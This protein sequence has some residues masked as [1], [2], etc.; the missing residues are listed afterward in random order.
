MNSME[1]ENSGKEKNRD[2]EKESR[3]GG[4]R[5]G[6]QGSDVVELESVGVTTGSRSGSGMTASSL[7]GGGGGVQ[8]DACVFRL[9]ESMALVHAREIL[10]LSNRYISSQLFSCLVFSVLL[11]CVVLCCV[12]L[13]CV[14]CV[15]FSCYCPILSCVVCCLYCTCVCFISSLYILY[16]YSFI[17][18]NHLILFYRLF[19]S[20][21]FFPFLLFI[22]PLHSA[23]FIIFIFLHFTL[24]SFHNHSLFYFILLIIIRT[25]S[26][27]DTYFCIDTLLRDTEQDF[28][29]L[30]PLGK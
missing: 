26:G 13:C 11:C 5:G 28:S 10:A 3:E 24:F 4:E 21:I 27:G 1:D 29:I 16:Y 2:R 25:Q 9:S 20:I 23:H 18:F 7:I 30:T 22:T 12:V 17:L 6:V 8:G 14:L 19:I 15:V